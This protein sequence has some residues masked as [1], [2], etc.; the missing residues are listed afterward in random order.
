[1]EAEREQ[2]IRVATTQIASERDA[3][4]AQ[5]NASI[6]SQRQGLAQDMEALMTR[7][8]DRLFVCALIVVA[9][10][11]GLA[12]VAALALRSGRGRGRDS[13]GANT[14]ALVARH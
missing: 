4:I 5:L 1:V 11:V 6:Q 3:T 7:S 8:I 12:T 9:V 2:I 13:D 14:L 10:A